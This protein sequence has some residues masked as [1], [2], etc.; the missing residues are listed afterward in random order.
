MSNPIPP[1]SPPASGSQPPPQ[2]RHRRGLRP[3][4][5]ASLVSLAVALVMVGV[6]AAVGTR[7]SHPEPEYIVELSDDSLVEVEVEEGDPLGELALL[8]LESPGC[9][10]G[11]PSGDL[12]EMNVR[13]LGQWEFGSEGRTPY[14]VYEFEEPGTHTVECTEEVDG[15]LALAAESIDA[16]ET[17]QQIW[18]VTA[19]GVPTVAVLLA[20]GL[21]LATF[22]R[23]R[24]ESTARPPQH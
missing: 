10:H 14:F 23:S 19:L 8:S 3:G 1:Q 4:Y 20:I 5:L 17:R 9:V 2:P 15:G 12:G 24:K 22:L 16:A 7:I 13:G 6:V 11:L 18:A 21:A